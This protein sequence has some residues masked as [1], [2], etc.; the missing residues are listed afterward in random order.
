[1]SHS[2]RS[3][4]LHA[5]TRLSFIVAVAIIVLWAPRARA[6]TVPVSQDNQLRSQLGLGDAAGCWR[7]LGVQQNGADV[8]LAL[9]G[10]GTQIGPELRAI[11]GSS[12]VT[13]ASSQGGAIN[14]LQAT[15]TVAQYR[16]VR[17]RID[18]R[19]ET[20]RRPNPG[21]A[22]SRMVAPYTPLPSVGTDGQLGV[23]GEIELERRDRIATSYENGYQADISGLNVGVDY[24]LRNGVIGAFI[25]RSHQNAGLDDAGALIASPFG[26]TDAAF[27]RLLDD[28]A[29]RAAVCGGSPELSSFT[30]DVT[31]IG[32]FVGRRL[33]TNGF[34]DG[35][36]SGS[37]RAHES[38]RAICAIENQGAPAFAANVVFRD[39]NSNGRI[40]AGEVQAASGR[41]I[42]FNDDNN[43][44]VPNVNE[45]VF[46]DIFAGTLSNTTRIQEV[47]A[48][49]R[50]G[51]DYGTR[52]WRVGP[53]VLATVSRA[54]TGAYL[55]TGSSS[56]DNRVRSNDGTVIVRSLGGPIGLELAYDKQ[57]RTSMQLD[58]GGE[59]GYRMASRVGDVVP[60]IAAYWRHEFVD[61]PQ[62]IT[63]HMAQD[64]R[65]TPTRFAYA[66]DG[67][68]PNAA[69]LALGVSVDV[70]EHLA[71]RVDVSRLASD[72]FFQSSML[73]AHL[74]W[75]F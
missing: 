55:E 66:T 37:R 52:T 62:M 35:V 39:A 24:L 74:R 46:D 47:S 44:G 30:Q 25:G 21:R 28:A 57:S 70:G 6:Q 75:R 40:D 27:R 14:S 61:D 72:T 43:N 9:K 18:Q 10:L 73:T 19:L 38:S 59:I 68:D 64:L 12:Q 33:G 23:F 3:H 4:A 8:D 1:M 51:A 11:C 48:S 41:G 20:K 15:K 49:L 56:A 5:G 34:I 32:G 65:A 13:S 7:L 60:Y 67:R 58:A 2:R 22:L 69:L 50:A 71:M 63:V 42:L 53:R 16:L 29:V 45:S 36:V 54:T 17:R 26:T 31:R